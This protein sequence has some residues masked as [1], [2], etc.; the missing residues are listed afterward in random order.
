MECKGEG[1]VWR[2]RVRVEWV[3]RRGKMDPCL[4]Y[5]HSHWPQDLGGGRIAGQS[6]VINFL[7]GGG[8]QVL[9]DPGRRCVD[10]PNL[11]GGRGVVVYPLNI[12]RYSSQG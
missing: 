11:V 1:V 7:G 10:S 6:G 5:R 9:C 8:C 3:R 2:V 12:T 4:V